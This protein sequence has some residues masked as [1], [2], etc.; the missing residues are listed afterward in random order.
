M[1]LE[2]HV[3]LITFDN[4]SDTIWERLPVKEC[5]PITEREYHPQNCTALNDAVGGA[6]N[7]L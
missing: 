4:E 2:V 1:K 3:T 6:I 5:S 7:E